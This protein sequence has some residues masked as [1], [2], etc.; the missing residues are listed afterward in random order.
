MVAGKASIR[1][2]KCRSPSPNA[3]SCSATSRSKSV[4]NV[5]SW[6]DP[7]RDEPLS[8]P[9]R[10]SL[11]GTV[12]TVCSSS[13]RMRK[14]RLDRSSLRMMACATRSRALATASTRAASR[15]AKSCPSGSSRTS[16]PFRTSRKKRAIR[17]QARGSSQ[18]VPCTTLAFYAR[19]KRAVLNEYDGCLKSA[20]RHNWCMELT[21][22]SPPC[23]LIPPPV[24]S[25]SSPSSCAGAGR[26]CS[27]LEKSKVPW[28]TFVRL[29]LRPVRT[30]TPHSRVYPCMTHACYVGRITIGSRGSRLTLCDVMVPELTLM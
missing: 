11:N 26:R 6:S 10:V 7:G 28:A 5:A 24:P 13:S 15:S 21:S 2:R 22:C 30:S 17:T 1:S 29:Q 16:H 23:A 9:G 4:L 8:V 25:P 19:S 27:S 3:L 14:D 20:K 18:A 12:A